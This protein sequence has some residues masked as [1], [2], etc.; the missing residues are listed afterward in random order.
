M[1]TD[2]VK[3]QHGYKIRGIEPPDLSSYDASVR[4]LFWSWVVDLGLKRKDKEL[5]E[6]LDKNGKP[7]R[8]IAQATREH[9]RSAMTPSGKGD[10]AAPPLIP[11]WQKS[12]TRSLL[13]GRATSTHADFY[14]RY[15]SWTGDS[16]A[17]VLSYQ[18]ARG[19]DV[20]GISTPGLA[21]IKVHAWAIWERYKLGLHRPPMVATTGRAATVPSYGFKKVGHVELGATAS[22]GSGA[23]VTFL[24]GTATNWSTPQQRAAWRRETAPATLP[25]RAANPGAKSPISGPGYNRLLGQLWGGGGGASPGGSR[26]HP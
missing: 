18:A 7:L 3:I 6:G 14:W 10:P 22:G 2:T 19:R 12:R 23:S 25:G 4:K 24:P 16:W 17:V 21:W 26:R 8:A 5:A 15:D 11:G 1:T 13:A 9:R 20:F